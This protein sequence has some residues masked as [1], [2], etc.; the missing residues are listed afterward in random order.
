MPEII[1]EQNQNISNYINILQLP[2]SS[3]IRNHMFNMVS[4]IIIRESNKCVYAIYTKLTR[5]PHRSKSFGLHKNINK[6]MGKKY[7]FKYTT[8]LY[9]KIF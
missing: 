5:T 2:Y 4:G 9:Y 6:T 8:S 1:I 7:H 3:S